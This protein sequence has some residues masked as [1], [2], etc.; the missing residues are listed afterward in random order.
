MILIIKSSILRHIFRSPKIDAT[1][2]E[3]EKAAWTVSKS[4]RT[5][6][7]FFGWSDSFWREIPMLE[8]LVNEKKSYLKLKVMSTVRTSS[9]SC[10]GFPTLRRADTWNK[11]TCWMGQKCVTLIT[12][13]N[14]KDFWMGLR[15]CFFFFWGGEAYK[16]IRETSRNAYS[17]F[18]PHS[19]LWG[20]AKIGLITFETPGKL[21]VRIAA[22]YGWQQQGPR[23]E[24]PHD[25][26][27]YSMIAFYI[28]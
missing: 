17:H 1:K 19:S 5:A 9:S 7:S 25:R 20:W 4:S 2:P 15:G 10:P 28:L 26:N 6:G 8:L 24:K 16:K 18:G 12:S 13:S 22:R 21:L 27:K 3:S 14:H 11:K 23:R